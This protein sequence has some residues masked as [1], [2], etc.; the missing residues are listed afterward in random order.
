MINTNSIEKAKNQIKNEPSPVIVHSQNIEFNRKILDYGKFDVFL[1][2][3]PKTK[4]KLKK[5]ETEFD[6]VMA[7][8]A[9]KNK[10]SLGIDLSELRNLNK[11]EKALALT[12]LISIINVAKKNK[13]KIVILNPYNKNSIIPLITSL[14]GST[15]LNQYIF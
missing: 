7:K 9:K 10:V 6:Y 1:L 5:V 13:N 15:N 12:K 8:S 4:N 2:K 11:Q 14:G 3:L